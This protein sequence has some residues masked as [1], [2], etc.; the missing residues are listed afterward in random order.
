MAQGTVTVNNLNLGQGA[1]DEI[2]R[3][4]LFLGVGDT[5]KN[6]VLALNSQSDLD[7]LLGA[8]DSQLKTQ[9]M[10]AQANGGENWNAWAVPLDVSDDWKTALDTAMQSVSPELVAVCTPALVANDLDVAFAKAESIRTSLGRRVGILVATPC[11]DDTS[12]SWSDYLAAQAAIVDPVNAYRVSAV[13]L[14]H[15]NNLGELVGRLCNRAASVADSPMRVATGPLLAL[16]SV[17][18]DKDGVPLDNA[19]L[20]SLDALRLSVPQTYVDY[21]GTYWGDCN[22]LDAEGGD[23]QVIENL[24]VVDKAARAIRVLAIARIG[25]RQLN[26]TPISIASNKT[27]FSRPL[28]EM[29]RS[30]QFGAD[31]FPGEIKQ[32]KDG[33]I[34]IIWPTRDK[35]EIYLKVTPYNAPKSI[36]A[37]IALDLTNLG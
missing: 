2:E 6:S 16:G 35:V 15:G 8:N 23:Y 24:R 28:R 34:E 21:P 26:S 14:L 12:E 13:P 31:V 33:D 20:A 4:A 19:M 32:P 5:N 9:V 30:V 3:K 10:A 37:N 18:N 17:P 25:N 11:I 29:A 22:M 7:E 36:T 1:F 27:Y